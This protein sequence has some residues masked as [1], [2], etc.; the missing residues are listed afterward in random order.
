MDKTKIWILASAIVMV[1]I[2]ALGW[3]V[4]VDPQL[5]AKASTDEQ[6]VSVEAQNTATEL[7]IVKL[8]KDFES[9][10]ELKT[11][12]AGLRSSIPAAGELPDFL[13]QLDNLAAG[14]KTK[15]ISLTVSEAIPYT[16]PATA[17]PPVAAPVDGEE[18]AEPEADPVAEPVAPEGP[19]VPTTITDPR[20]TPENFVAIPVD[21]TVE[22]E[23]DAAR[24]FIDKLQHGP[25]LFMAT[26]IAIMPIEERP[27]IF[28]T[29]VTGYVYVLL[30][31]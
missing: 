28:T 26:S 13:T 9:I 27:G 20:I 23:R 5:K 8:K 6:R 7:A 25:R 11:E 16:V 3:F 10:D 15:V 18:S 12:L 17:V 2:L 30:Q 31:K 21:V 4:G 14:S 1:G 22:G 29:Q 19:A 24:S